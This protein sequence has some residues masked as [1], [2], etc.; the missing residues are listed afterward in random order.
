MSLMY[1]PV[2]ASIALCYTLLGCGSSAMPPV[3]TPPAETP[4]PSRPLNDTGTRFCRDLQGV[5]A[6]C[7]DAP[8]QDGNSGRDSQKIAKAGGGDAG[9]DFTKLGAHGKPLASQDVGWNP[10][11]TAATGEQWRC[12]KDNHTGLIWEVKNPAP[13]SLNHRDYL[14]EWHSENPASNGGFAGESSSR[15]CGGIPCDTQ[16]F[17]AAMNVERWCGV[18]RWRLPTAAE[19]LSIVVTDHLALVADQAYFP[20]TQASHYWTSQSFAPDNTK[21]W[22][23]YFSDGSIANTLKSQPMYVRLVAGP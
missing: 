10:G 5:N 13:G 21:A 16:A 3:E 12:V 20:E 9:L 8:A 11:G 14:Y 18:N 7:A 1:R 23:G 2:F 15:R 6:P 19:L 22:Y 4:Y 17:I